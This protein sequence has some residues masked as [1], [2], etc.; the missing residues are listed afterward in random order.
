MRRAPFG[1]LRTEALPTDTTPHNT[2]SSIVAVALLT[3]GTT[4]ADAPRVLTT[5]PDAHGL[6]A[7][8]DFLADDR[9][10][11]AAHAWRAAHALH[12][13]VAG[14]GHRLHD[15][16]RIEGIAEHGLDGVLLEGAT[17]WLPPAAN[18]IPPPLQS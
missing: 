5:A 15:P 16:A 1:A 14:F 4:M 2:G 17:D 3:H 10:M 9:L 12:V 8:E 13:A 7:V 18:P 11:L 6:C